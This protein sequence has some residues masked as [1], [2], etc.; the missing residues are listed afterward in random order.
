[1]KREILNMDGMEYMREVEDK[2]FDVC[3]TSPPYNM[4]L[5]V[6]SKGDGYCSRQIKKEISSKYVGFDDNLPM[7]DYKDFLF[8]YAKEMLRV[9]DVVFLNIQL[10]TGNKPALFSFMGEFSSDIK[11]LIIWDKCKAQP[12]IGSGVMNSGYELIIVLGGSPITRAFN[13]SFFGR[14]TLDNL[15]RVPT[16]KS[17]NK[18]HG[19]AFPVSLAEKILCNFSEKGQKV[20]DPF[21]GTGTSA[22]AAHYAECDFVGCEINKNYY[23]SAIERIERETAQLDMFG[24][25]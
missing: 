24:A 25:A 8:K 17:S 1:M 7:D 9:S 5:R 20:L 22:I 11:E 23:D 10:I 4:N 2:F 6:N 21:L 19:A 3:M 14:G 16:E 13:P 12:A 18:D 15:W